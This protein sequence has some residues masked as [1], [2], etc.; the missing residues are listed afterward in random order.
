MKATERPAQARID[1]IRSIGANVCRAL[2]TGRADRD[3][4]PPSKAHKN[5][6]PE[7]GL[8]RKQKAAETILVFI[9]EQRQRSPPLFSRR[10][11]K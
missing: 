4:S 7:G 3:I 11:K 2:A 9:L 1:R 8:F 5:A 10:S 6:P